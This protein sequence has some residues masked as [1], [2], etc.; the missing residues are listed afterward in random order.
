MEKASWA[1]VAARDAAQ[2]AAAEAAVLALHLSH[3]IE[4]RQSQLQGTAEPAIQVFVTKC[5]PHK[6]QW[7]ESFRVTYSQGDYNFASGRREVI[8]TSNG[9]EI[10][11][12]LAA[13]DQ[14]IQAA[15]ALKLLALPP[16]EIVARL[17]ALE[18]DLAQLFSEA[19]IVPE[20]DRLADT[21]RDKRDW[22][23]LITRAHDRKQRRERMR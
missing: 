22:T 1:Y 5:W 9:A 13:I 17:A 8:E 21:M 15:E 23:R 14:Q 18:Q 10:R 11:E 20:W 16:K 3:N 6:G 4:R 7:R 12:A 2:A 19:W